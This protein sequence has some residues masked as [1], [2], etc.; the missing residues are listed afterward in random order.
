MVVVVT[1]PLAPTFGNKILFLN[2]SPTQPRMIYFTYR[3]PAHSCMFTSN[4]LVLVYSKVVF[5]CERTEI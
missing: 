4:V 1:T 5:N 2:F 3:S